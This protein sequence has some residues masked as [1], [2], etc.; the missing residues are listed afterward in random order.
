MAA[1]KGW[2]LSREAVC[3]VE[4]SGRKGVLGHTLVILGTWAWKGKRK[5]QGE[6]KEKMLN[7]WPTNDNYRLWKKNKTKQSKTKNNMWMTMVH[8]DIPFI[9][10]SQESTSKKHSAETLRAAAFGDLWGLWFSQIRLF[11]MQGRVPGSCAHSPSASAPWKV[12]N[13]NCFSLE[14]AINISNLTK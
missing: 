6:E 9:C 12:L 11:E 14:R 1:S 2:E 5:Q 13:N 8:A 3:M 10:I 7:K 4:K